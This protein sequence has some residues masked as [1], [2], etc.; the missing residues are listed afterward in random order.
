M[1]R[2]LEVVTWLALAGAAVFLLDAFSLSV[3]QTILSEGFYVLALTGSFALLVLGRGDRRALFLS[4]LLLAASVW[5]RSAGL[6]AVP[7]WLV[8]VAWTT[9]AWRPTLLA[10]SALA[11]PLILY[12]T[13]YS[14]VTGIFGFTQTKGW[15]MYGRVAEIA[16]CRTADIPA[17][18]R[19][20]CPKPPV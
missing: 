9:R 4:G 6:F 14:Q 7:A 2:R 20:L 11:L 10:A 5:L 18:T 16:N 3:E 15:F 1:L 8:Y 12:M 19:R 17:G 13:L